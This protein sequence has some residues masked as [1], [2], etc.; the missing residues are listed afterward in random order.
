MRYIKLV[1]WSKASKKAFWDELKKHPGI[2]R[3]EW[4]THPLNENR[5]SPKEIDLIEFVNDINH[6][7]GQPTFFRQATYVKKRFN[8]SV[9]TFRYH[10]RKLELLG[11]IITEIGYSYGKRINRHTIHP[12][13]DKYKQQA[14]QLASQQTINFTLPSTNSR[15]TSDQSQSNS[16][17]QM[18]WKCQ[19]FYCATTL[20]QDVE[21][22]ASKQIKE[23]ERIIQHLKN[24]VE[25]HQNKLENEKSHNKFNRQEAKGK[26]KGKEALRR[27]FL[28]KLAPEQR[29]VLGTFE[30]VTGRRIDVKRD[31]DAWVK[32]S[33]LAP[34]NAIIGIMQS[35][36]NLLA[37]KQEGTPRIGKAPIYSLKYC[38]YQAYEIDRQSK[39]DGTMSSMAGYLG[40]LTAELEPET[41]TKMIELISQLP[42][43]AIPHKKG[44]AEVLGQFA[45]KMVSKEIIAGNIAAEEKAQAY[46]EY[47]G[48]LEVQSREKQCLDLN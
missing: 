23:Q 36:V 30:V 31:Y 17:A 38:I 35:A 11:L 10:L 6:K 41:A 40:R 34:I 29:A 48:W 13:F 4:L 7:S 26:R 12:D 18:C 14:D 42:A 19:K 15:S 28:S 2:S 46:E 22:A 43:K 8:W 44:L 45:S 9:S 21:T 3:R 5:L 27:E 24:Q 20:E 1:R 25:I 33:Q 16:K 39:I 47:Y 32:L 37:K